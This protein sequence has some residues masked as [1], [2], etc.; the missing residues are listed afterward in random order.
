MLYTNKVL[1]EFHKEQYNSYSI[2]LFFLIL[3]FA[4]KFEKEM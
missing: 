1:F 2:L 3:P 4:I